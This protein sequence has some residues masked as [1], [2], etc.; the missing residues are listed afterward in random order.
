MEQEKPKIEEKIDALELQLRSL[1]EEKKYYDDINSYLEK[2]NIDKSET[3]TYT[4]EKI[5]KLKGN[6]KNKKMWGARHVIGKLRDL[7]EEIEFE[8]RYNK[9][10]YVFNNLQQKGDDTIRKKLI[11]IINDNSLTGAFNAENLHQSYPIETF[12]EN[13]CTELYERKMT[14]RKFFNNTIK[15]YLIKKD[16]NLIYD[17]LDPILHLFKESDS[18]KNPLP[19]FPSKEFDDNKGFY[20]YKFK[21]E[22]IGYFTGEMFVKMIPKEKKFDTILSSFF[23]TNKYLNKY[24][25]KPMKRKEYKKITHLIRAYHTES[26]AQQAIQEKDNAIRYF[27]KNLSYKFHK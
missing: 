18:R 4:I 13:I 5:K 9:I 25:L 21:G 12:I 2:N 24:D 27:D 22:R 15:L 19:Y 1:E 26:E 10:D 23:K 16:K 3:N 11:T 17:S 8:E 6:K 14:M 20:T 7:Y